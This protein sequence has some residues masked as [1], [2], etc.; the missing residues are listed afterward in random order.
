MRFQPYTLQP[1]LH[2]KKH[3]RDY[4]SGPKRRRRREQTV[5]VADSFEDKA[6][7]WARRMWG[8][9]RDHSREATA[10]A[11]GVALLIAAIVWYFVKEAEQ[12]RQS[13]ARLTRAAETA[14]RAA[15]AGRPQSKAKSGVAVDAARQCEQ[16][17][18][19]CGSTS[20]TPY[21]QLQLGNTRYREGDLQRARAAY[22]E[23]AR[24]YPKHFAGKLG[25]LGKAYAL[26]ELH[27][28]ADA[29]DALGQLQRGL[30]ALREDKD[31]PH[32]L[33]AQVLYDR[34]RCLEAAGKPEAAKKL[35]VELLKRAPDAGLVA[36]VQYRLDQIATG[37]PLGVKPPAPAKSKTPAKRE[38][39]PP[40]PKGTERPDA[41]VK[42]PIAEAPGRAKQKAKAHGAA[43]VDN[44]TTP[45]AKP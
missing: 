6:M 29:A 33:E 5:E 19:D 42:A 30:V 41:E 18:R 35:Y 2:A 39:A 12:E 10:I 40:A 34:G 15:Q 21:V 24:K 11:A 17:M 8:L 26:E 32:F 38:S 4:Y 45:N 36:T 27:K 13:W 16:I 7:Q 9:A 37:V 14:K 31:R 44:G 43:K 28:F 3:D 20:A 1:K 23:L 22:G 25:L